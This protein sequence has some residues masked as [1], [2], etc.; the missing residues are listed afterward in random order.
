LTIERLL[1]YFMQ[2]D[3]VLMHFKFEL[4]EVG[5][6]I[7][8][9]HDWFIDMADYKANINGLVSTKIARTGHVPLYTFLECVKI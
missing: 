7:R 4:A 6:S 5:W 8:K 3:Q 1:K 9:Y 2:I